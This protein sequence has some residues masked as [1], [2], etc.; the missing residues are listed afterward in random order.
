MDNCTQPYKTLQNSKD[1][2]KPLQNTKNITTL[3]KTKRCKN[4][5]KLVQI[6]AIFLF[7]Q[8]YIYNST[9]L[10]KTCSRFNNNST[11]LHTTL[12]HHINHKIVQDLARHYK[13]ALYRT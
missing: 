10:T 11:K 3:L 4:H 9:K 6:C 5:T 2:T 8:K 7:Q 12:Q 13:K 1:F